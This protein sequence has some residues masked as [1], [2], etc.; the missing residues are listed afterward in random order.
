MADAYNGHDNSWY[1]TEVSELCAEL[2]QG[3]NQKDVERL[4]TDF[5]T[6]QMT[7]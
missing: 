2:C 3:Y 5:F 6:R 4:L 1:I 7:V